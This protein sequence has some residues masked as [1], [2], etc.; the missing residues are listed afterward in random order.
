MTTETKKEVK[1][2]TV[3]GKKVEPE[4]VVHKIRFKKEPIWVKCN[5]VG[6]YNGIKF[7]FSFHEFTSQDA[8][9]VIRTFS[10][11]WPGRIPELKSLAEN[12]IKEL[13]L[14][15]K[16]SEDSTIKMEVIKADDVFSDAE[17]LA[18]FEKLVGVDEEVSLD[19]DI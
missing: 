14:K 10:F 16:H 13:F 17:E 15:L 2:L 11:T 8:D 4:K 6:K 19:E 12:G 9:E 1:V 3:K 5:F 7:R 18:E